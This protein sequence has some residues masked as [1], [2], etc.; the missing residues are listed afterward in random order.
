MRFLHTGD[1]HIGKLLAGYN[2]LEDQHATFREMETIAKKEH[3]DAV[4]IAG[5]LYDRTMPSEGAINELSAE[6]ATLNLQDHFPVLAISGNHDSATRL[7]IGSQWFSDRQLFINTDFSHAFNP[8]DLDDT[9]FF[10]LPFFGLQQARNYFQDESIKDINTAM[11][12]IVEAM[13]HRFD[14]SKKHVLVA[15]F[16]AAG[17]HHTA[18]SEILIEVGGLSAVN[19]SLLSDF[20][21]VALGHLH[22]KNALHEERVRYSGSPMKFSVSEANMEKGVWIVDTDPFNVKWV[23]L[24]PIHDLHVLEESMVTLIDHQFA[25]QYSPDD[26]Y[27]IKLCDRDIIPDVMNRL[28]KYYPKIVSLGRKY[29][30]ANPRERQRRVDTKLSPAKQFADFFQETVGKKLSRGQSQIVNETLAEIEKEG[31]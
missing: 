15:H 29:G 20:D 12:K 19:T 22:N 14:P 16:F 6:L 31:R 23:P 1:W 5:D 25:K 24:L 21:Y 27:A 18:E 8:V 3:V 26:Y 4:V 17:S 10:L 7:G 11:K 13:R 2:L 30:F 28:R 9:Q